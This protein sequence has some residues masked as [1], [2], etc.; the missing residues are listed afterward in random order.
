MGYPTVVR[1]E[2]SRLLFLKSRLQ[3][4]PSDAATRQPPQRHHQALDSITK[5]PCSMIIAS[6]VSI[7]IARREGGTTSP[8]QELLECGPPQCRKPPSHRKA[9]RHIETYHRKYAA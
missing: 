4:T 7:P 6:D 5:T 8:D 3:T 2:T 9:P 1:S